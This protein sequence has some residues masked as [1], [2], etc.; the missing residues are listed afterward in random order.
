[1]QHG[2][3]MNKCGQVAQS[4]PQQR[5]TRK[6][7]QTSAAKRGEYLTP[8][9]NLNADA[10]QIPPSLKSQVQVQENRYTIPT[11]KTDFHIQVT[12]AN[13]TKDLHEELVQEISSKVP[14]SPPSNRIHHSEIFEVD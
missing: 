4:L 1:M 13:R 9:H 11:M 5:L 3:S 6:L 8:T 12:L 7:R 10:F 14:K 2:N